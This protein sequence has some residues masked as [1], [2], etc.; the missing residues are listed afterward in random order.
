MESRI[1]P[2]QPV[3]PLGNVDEAFAWLEKA[4]QNHD[5]FRI[6]IKM[7]SG[8]ENGSTPIRD[9]ACAQTA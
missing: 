7:K 6:A 3:A 9:S 5:Y 8:S 2:P 1:I 4:C